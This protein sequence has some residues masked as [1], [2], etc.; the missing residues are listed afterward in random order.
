[1]VVLGDNFLYGRD[2]FSNLE[3]NFISSE[4]PSIYYQK[5]RNLELFG[6]IKWDEDNILDIIEKP[7]NTY[8]TMLLLVFIYLILTF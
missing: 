8:L 4:K 6:V 5:V 7:S 2:F 3:S 1:M